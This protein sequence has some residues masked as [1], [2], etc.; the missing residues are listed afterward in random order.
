MPDYRENATELFGGASK[1]SIFE[2]S[3]VENGRE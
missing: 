1:A 3:I 2:D